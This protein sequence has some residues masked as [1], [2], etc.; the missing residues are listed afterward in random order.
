MA[1]DYQFVNSTEAVPQNLNSFQIKVGPK[2]DIWRVPSR[3]DF[4]APVMYR[5]VPTATFRSARLT[6]FADWERLYDQGGLIMVLPQKE[7]ATEPTRAKWIKAGVEIVDGKPYMGVVATDR[8]SDF[9]VR[10]NQGRNLT[11]EFERKL[12]DGAPQAALWIYAIEGVERTPVREVT[13]AFEE[14]DTADGQIWI[15]A[16]A[17]RPNDEPGE[18]VVSF[19][20]LKIT[21][22]D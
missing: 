10:P 5:T 20:D 17:A 9:S 14:G 2:T 6:V 19:S 3:N 22:T 16:Y 12:K 4:T 8:F 11:L 15:G 13:W 18:L 7:D 21:T 1:G